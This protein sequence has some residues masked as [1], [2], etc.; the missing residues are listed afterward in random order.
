MTHCIQISLDFALLE[1][2]HP[3]EPSFHRFT[4]PLFFYFFLFHPFTLACFPRFFPFF[5]IIFLLPFFLY[6]FV[7]EYFLLNSTLFIK[8]GESVSQSVCNQSHFIS[9]FHQKSRNNH[10][11]SLMGVTASIIYILTPPPSLPPQLNLY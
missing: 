2:F 6:I 1:P 3:L 4:F 10:S 7:V 5:R 11:P 9:E 8:E